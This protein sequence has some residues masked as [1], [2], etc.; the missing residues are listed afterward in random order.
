ME[1]DF[2]LEYRLANKVVYTFCEFSF[3]A[4]AFLYIQL[5]YKFDDLY[6]ILLIDWISKSRLLFTASI[7]HFMSDENVRKN[8][9]TILKKITVNIEHCVLDNKTFFFSRFCVLHRFSTYFVLQRKERRAK[10]R[11]RER[12][13]RFDFRRVENLWMVRN[14]KRIMTFNLFRP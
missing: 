11:E 10:E 14:F 12:K 5:L 1:Q 13:K 9:I 3:I 8:S 6:L 4:C 2:D 7:G